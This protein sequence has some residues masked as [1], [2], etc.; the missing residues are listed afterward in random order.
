M[1]LAEYGQLQ[2]R[3]ATRDGIKKQ[4]GDK[5]DHDQLLDVS[6]RPQAKHVHHADQVPGG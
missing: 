2:P 3:E 5:T 6:G 4:R 1:G